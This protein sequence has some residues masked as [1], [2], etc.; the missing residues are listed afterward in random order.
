MREC[1][2]KISNNAIQTNLIR[3]NNIDS[4]QARLFT[5]FLVT[6]KVI[7]DHDHKL[8]QNEPESD[9]SQ[10]PLPTRLVSAENDFHDTREEFVLTNFLRHGIEKS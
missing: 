3:Y 4:E 6:Q 1:P 9:Q 10:K 5:T 2:H 7:P 8:G